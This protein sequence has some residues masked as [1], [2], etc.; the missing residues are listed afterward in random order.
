MNWLQEIKAQD[1]AGVNVG[2]LDCFRGAEKA[3]GKRRLL[4]EP[5]FGNICLDQQLLLWRDGKGHS[6]L[7]RE[8]AEKEE[9][10]KGRPGDA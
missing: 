8:G 5:Y 3:L 6:V 10:G 1:W 4:V 9:W 7:C 2:A